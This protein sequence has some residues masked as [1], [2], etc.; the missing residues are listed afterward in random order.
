MKSYIAI[1][2]SRINVVASSHSVD[3]MSESRGIFSGSYWAFHRNTLLF[4]LALLIISLPEVTLD[5]DQT[6]L[7]FQFSHLAGRAFRWALALAATYA[8]VAYYLEWKHEAYGFYLTEHG[9]IQHQDA[10]VAAVVEAIEAQIAAGEAYQAAA[11]QK[12]EQLKE[13]VSNYRDQIASIIRENSQGSMASIELDRAITDLNRKIVDD[14]TTGVSR[15][16]KYHLDVEFMKNLISHPE[17]GPR[18]NTTIRDFV[19]S[20]VSMRILEIT[21]PQ[22]SEFDQKAAAFIS[23]QTQSVSTISEVAPPLKEYNDTLSKLRSKLLKQKRLTTLR[24]WIFG[25]G[26]ALT[27]YCIAVAHFVGSE[28]FSWMPAITHF[29]PA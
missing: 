22:T 6:V 18:I 13:L 23:D 25:F 14:F 5:S 27:L 12:L 20:L 19:T 24:V 8:C 28:L 1:G 7:V 9:L 29:L 10:Q 11:L 21:L 2:L 15:L 3:D 4:S 17:V 26:A 16:P